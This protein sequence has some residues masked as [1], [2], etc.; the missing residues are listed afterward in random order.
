MKKITKVKER[1]L[2]K[3]LQ[4]ELTLRVAYLDTLDGN[5][6]MY[7]ESDVIE[8]MRLANGYKTRI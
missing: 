6:S 8:L 7:K 1:E 3:K 4:D 5:V 2:P